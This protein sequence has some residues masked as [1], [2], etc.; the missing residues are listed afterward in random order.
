MVGLPLRFGDENPLHAERAEIGDLRSFF[1][2]PTRDIFALRGHLIVW[3]F[4]DFHGCPIESRKRG[5]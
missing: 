4:S 5:W 3:S 1:A 2:M